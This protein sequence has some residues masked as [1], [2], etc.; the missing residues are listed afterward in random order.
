MCSP[1]PRRP[2]F[3]IFASGRNN[4]DSQ[5]RRTLWGAFI[6]LTVLVA[7]GLA[8]TVTILQMGKHQESR[9]VHGSEPLL[10]AVQQMDQDT[11]AILGASRGFLVTQQ[12]Q[13][14]EQYDNRVRDFQKQATTA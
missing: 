9:I 2:R 11:V 13:F 8:I 7:I 5:I 4:M 14:L 6:A 10:D 3:C 1:H 12:S